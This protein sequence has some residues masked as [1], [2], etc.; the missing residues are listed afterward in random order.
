MRDQIAAAL[1]GGEASLER[2]I[3]SGDRIQ[4]RPLTDIGGKALFTRE[5][6]EA[7]LAGRLDCAV[8]SMKDMPAEG[9][10]GLV[11]AAVPARRIPATPSSA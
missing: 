5:I 11:I 6:E 10:L 8:H 1:S 4:D 2:V 3:T 7:L 9:P